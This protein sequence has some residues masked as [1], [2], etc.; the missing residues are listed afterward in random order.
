MP[1][2]E[3]SGLVVASV[4]AS[5]VASGGNGCPGKQGNGC[6]GGRAMVAPVQWLPRS[7]T[8]AV[9]ALVGKAVQLME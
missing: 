6:P 2:A 7:V 1:G 4:V 9:I 8:G 5:L 3:A